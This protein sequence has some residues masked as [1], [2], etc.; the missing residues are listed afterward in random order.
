MTINLFMKK[1]HNDKVSV[2]LLFSKRIIIKIDFFSN[3]NLEKK[4]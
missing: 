1:N 4:V 2:K 3:L